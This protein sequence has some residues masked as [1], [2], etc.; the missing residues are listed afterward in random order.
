VAKLERCP[1]CGNQTSE[2]ATEC[3]ACGEPLSPGWAEDIKRGT[4]KTN[5]LIWGFILAVLIVWINWNGTNDDSYL[6]NLKETDSAEYQTRI[7]KLETQ[8]AKVPASDFNENIRL[9]SKLQKL[10]PDSARYADKITHYQRKQKEAEATAK[11]KAEAAR[12]AEEKAATLAAIAASKWYNGGTLHKANLASWS[13][14]T[15]KT[16]LATS[17]DFAAKLWEGRFS[18]MDE[19]KAHARDLKICIDEVAVGPQLG[20]LR[21]TEI[22]ASCAVLLGWAN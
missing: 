7:Q 9:Y 5:I 6:R 12:K 8:V 1:T 22:A 2:N 13:N 20:S 19:L 3:P 10:N 15:N 18:S 11:A 4:R 14:S 17:A 21:V 16:R